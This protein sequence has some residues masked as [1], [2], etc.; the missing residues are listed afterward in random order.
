TIVVGNPPYSLWSQNL[1]DAA[2]AIVDPY[3]AVDGVPIR[4]RG[5]LQFEKILQDDYVKF[6]RF[7]QSQIDDAGCGV[8]GIITNHSFLDNPTLRGMRNSLLQSL[9]NVLCV[10]LHG[11]TSKKERSPD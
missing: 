2:R 11:N 9:D 5:A 3:R 10:N 7:A 8:L 1:S 6:F 4:E